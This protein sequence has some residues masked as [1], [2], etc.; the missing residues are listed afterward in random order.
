CMHSALAAIPLGRRGAVS[1]AHSRRLGSLASDSSA[2]V[3]RYLCPPAA[4]PLPDAFG[5]KAQ[6][7]PACLLSCVSSG[8][9]LAPAT[10]PG[11]SAARCRTGAEERARLSG[12][13]I[14]RVLARRIRR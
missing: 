13:A 14:G 9:S 6:H 10:I 2:W 1:G 7:Q 4:P 8:G 11:A 5:R 12:A 3:Q